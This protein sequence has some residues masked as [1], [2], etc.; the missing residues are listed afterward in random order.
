MPPNKFMGRLH[1]G[2]Y[3]TVTVIVCIY[4]Y[5]SL[6]ISGKEESEF[7]RVRR[8]W[9]ERR[10][11]GP[12]MVSQEWSATSMCEALSGTLGITHARGVFLD[13]IVK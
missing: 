5:I 6:T 7:E 4:V 13:S 3:A 9:R 11:L 2:I 10:I 12:D 8:V 1:L